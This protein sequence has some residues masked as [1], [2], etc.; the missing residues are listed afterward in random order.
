VAASFVACTVGLV[1]L[2]QSVDNY[3]F[4]PRLAQ[5]LVRRLLSVGLPKSVSF[6]RE[7]AVPPF[8]DGYRTGN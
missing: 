5:R 2:A 8:V 3:R 1:R 6:S 4:R 7:A